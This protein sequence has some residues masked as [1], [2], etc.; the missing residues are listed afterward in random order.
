[1]HPDFHA[2]AK[3]A[4]KSRLPLELIVGDKEHRGK[5]GLCFE[6]SRSP[7]FGGKKV[8]LIDDADFFNSEVAN[9]LLKTLEEPP[10]NSLMILLGSS[11]AKQLPTIRSRCQT[12]RFQSLSTSDVAAVLK[13]HGIVGSDEQSLL[14]AKRA[15]GSIETA[16]EMMDDSLEVV[17]EDVMKL[18][19]VKRVNTI[20]AAATVNRAVDA[21]GKDDAPKKRQRLRFILKCAIDFYENQLR[22]HAKTNEEQARRD[23]SNIERIMTTIEQV[24]SNGNL[25]FV[26]EA[27]FNELCV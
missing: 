4:D 21:V 16:C 8:A 27:M 23:V 5:S 10:N 3:P 20:A 12:V 26:V 2:I 13:Q 19:S 6:I 17:R 18:L 15:D 24:D 1:T 7:Y 9:S 22:S 11:T 14:I 25:K